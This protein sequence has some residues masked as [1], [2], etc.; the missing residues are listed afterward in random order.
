MQR[1]LVARIIAGLIGLSPV[2]CLAPAGA[3]PLGT[4]FTY[5]GRLE[6]GGGPANGLYDLELKLFDVES[7]GIPV[8]PS[9]THEDV[10]VANGLFVVD[11][12]FGAA[13]HGAELYLEI[14]VRPGASTG[15]FTPLAPRQRIPAV[16]YAL[17]ALSG[18]G[19]GGDIT[20]VNPGFGLSGGATSGDATL[21]VDFSGSGGADTASRSDHDHFGQ[22][23]SGLGNGLSVASED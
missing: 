22:T 9:D 14:G 2:V 18:P 7:L 10:E 4:A 21:S 15:A 23:W 12:D 1:K 3:G 5:Q 6:D 11:V 20:S 13:F 16:P 19:S 17:Y 8:A